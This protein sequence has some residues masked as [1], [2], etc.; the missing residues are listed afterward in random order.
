MIRR[1]TF[2][3]QDPCCWVS[4]LHSLVKSSDASSPRRESTLQCALEEM[5]SF[6]KAGERQ[7]PWTKALLR[8]VRSQN[9]CLLLHVMSPASCLSLPCA[10]CTLLF[11]MVVSVTV[12]LFLFI[13]E[14]G[15]RSEE[16]NILIWWRS[17]CF[18]QGPWTLIRV[19]VIIRFWI[20]FLGNQIGPFF[21]GNELTSK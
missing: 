3:F 21:C 9:S 20:I 10:T 12:T 5:A 13:W 8:R 16:D 1:H 14:V 19:K 2:C 4:N 11:R 18:N 6:Q 15:Q 17:L 7:G